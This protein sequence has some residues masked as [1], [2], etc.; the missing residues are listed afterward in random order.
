[1]TAKLLSVVTSCYNEEGNVRALYEAVKEVM[2]RHPQ[3]RYEHIF[4]DNNSRDDTRMILREM[5]EEDVNVK[6]IF[7]ARNFGAIRSGI[8]VVLQTTGEAVIGLAC[9]FQDPPELID[10]FIEKWEQGAK[11]ILGVKTSAAERTLF[12]RI[13]GIYYRL[14]ASISEAPLVDQSTG[15]GMFDRVVIEALRKIDDPY[16]FFRGL[17]AEIGYRPELVPYH[18]PPRRRGI[19][20]QNFYRLYDHALLGITNHS[21]VPLRLAM[22]LGCAMGVL[23]SLVAFGYFIAKLLFWQ[24][25]SLGVAPILIGFFFL[26]SIQLLFLGIIGEYVGV[27]YTHV[28]RVP[29]VFELER[30]NFD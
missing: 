18:Q 24:Q 11:I 10:Q 8:H 23:S 19:S 20:S 29:H 17:L 21:R 7:N 9:D 2:A 22:M 12:Y 26:T 4:I 13:R 25:F 5:C 15:F 3:Y 16:P 27:I 28:R 1:M 6:A 30:I 14:L